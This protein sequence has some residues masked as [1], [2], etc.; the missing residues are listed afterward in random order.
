MC[1][2][3]N[4]ADGLLILMDADRMMNQ[5]AEGILWV[6]YGILV[7]YRRVCLNVTS[8]GHTFT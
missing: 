7:L 2:N 6:F 5:Q 8:G 4:R 1:E 3:E